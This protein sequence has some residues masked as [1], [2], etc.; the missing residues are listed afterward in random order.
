MRTRPLSDYLALAALTAGLC[1]VLAG[2]VF[3]T[4]ALTRPPDQR[5]LPGSIA[6]QRT[7]DYASDRDPSSPHLLPLDDEIVDDA[8]RD[9]PR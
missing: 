9:R 8:R 4:S 3:L 1:L 7:A 2:A 5:V 6:P